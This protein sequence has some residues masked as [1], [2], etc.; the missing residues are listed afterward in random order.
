VVAD[1][2]LPGGASATVSLMRR[3]IRGVLLPAGAARRAEA[4]GANSN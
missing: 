1:L 2:R 4:R 3:G